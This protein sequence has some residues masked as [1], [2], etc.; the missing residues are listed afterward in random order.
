MHRSGT[1]FL[2]GVLAG[3][4][5]A[6]GDRLLPA[7]AGNPRGYYEDEMV[8]AF[9]KQLL[10]ARVEKRQTRADFLQGAG[11]DPAWSDA[12]ASQARELVEKSR[13]EGLWGWKEPRTCLFLAQWLEILPQARCVAVYRHPLEVY[14]SFL[15][16]GDWSALFA[17]EAVFAAC[18]AYNGAILAARQAHPGNFLLL[19]AQEAFADPAELTRR[20]ARFLD[21]PEIPGNAESFVREEFTHLPV[22]REKHALLAAAFPAAAEVYDRMQL[23]ADRPGPFAPETGPLTDHGVLNALTS[24]ARSGSGMELLDAF[25]LPPK[26]G[27][28]FRAKIAADV[29]KRI[30]SLSGERD[31]YVANFNK[32]K[33]LY[34]NYF[35]AWQGAERTLAETR[36][37][38]DG[39]LLPKIERWRA[40]LSAQ[41]VPFE[42]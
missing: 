5:A 41:G 29:E 13:R 7:D 31:E 10:A 2:A 16:R 38:V 37:W 24:A 17:P 15:K 8:L 25:A 6:M 35:A 32:Y 4:G 40:L 26:T 27:A 14:Y 12:E 20:L 3:M 1:S 18:A 39:D 42:E 33:A 36:R 9:H 23:A 22:S 30:A 34:E 28:A 21:L 19:H 11:F